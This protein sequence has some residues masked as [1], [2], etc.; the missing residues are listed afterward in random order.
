MTDAN[1][2]NTPPAASTEPVVQTDPQPPAPVVNTEPGIPIP[3]A[4]PLVP[5]DQDPVYVQLQIEK[6]RN[7]KLRRLLTL[8]QNR[9]TV[10][11]VVPAASVPPG[12]EPEPDSPPAPVPVPNR[13]DPVERVAR[14]LG[15]TKKREPRGGS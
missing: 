5:P 1:S 8:N 6:K 11:P 9:S 7:K 14:F 2:P 15:G 10:V 3:A 13:A 4:G 12:T